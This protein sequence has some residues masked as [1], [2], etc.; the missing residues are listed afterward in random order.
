MNTNSIC[1]ECEHVMTE[2]ICVECFE[3]QMQS[4]VY[5]QGASGKQ[6]V[7]AMKEIGNVTSAVKM[8]SFSSF[9]C[10]ICMKKVNNMC[11]HCLM[12]KAFHVMR[13]NK[14]KEVNLMFDLKSNS[15][16]IHRI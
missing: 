1:S 6:A 2:P 16:G 10:V 5:E 12:K 9:R 3:R 7:M 15:V 13:K 11:N 4:L 8:L 14:V